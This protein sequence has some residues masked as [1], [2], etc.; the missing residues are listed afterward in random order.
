MIKEK[1]GS[2]EVKFSKATLKLEKSVYRKLMGDESHG[3]VTGFGSG[4]FAKDLRAKH[5]HN[6]SKLLVKVLRMMQGMQNQ[7]D[8]LTAKVGAQHANSPHESG[9]SISVLMSIQQQV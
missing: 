8:A 3:K 6:E 2:S 7:I 1:T 5:H 9:C 4:V